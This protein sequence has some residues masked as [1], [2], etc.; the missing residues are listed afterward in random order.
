MNA[1]FAQTARADL[2]ALDLPSEG[3]EWNLSLGSEYPGASGNLDLQEEDSGMSLLLSGDFTQGGAYVAAELEL[4]DLAEESLLFLKLQYRSERAAAMALRLIDETGQVFQTSLSL[5]ADSGLHEL[6]FSAASESWDEY[7]GGAGDGIWRGGIAYLSLILPHH[8][9]PDKTPEI[10]FT[11]IRLSATEGTGADTSVVASYSFDD[12]E[13]VVDWQLSFATLASNAEG[14]GV[15]RLQRS[16]LTDQPVAKSPA[17]AIEGNRLQVTASGSTSLGSPDNS[18]RLVGE[19]IFLNEGQGEIQKR[20]AF[21]QSGESGVGQLSALLSV[22]QDAAYA[23]FQARIEK[24]SGY[25]DIEQVLI[26]QIHEDDSNTYRVEAWSERL[27]NLF[28]PEEELAFQVQASSGDADFDDQTYLLCTVETYWGGRIGPL[29]KPTLSREERVLSGELGLASLPLE[30]GRFYSLRVSLVKAG[31]LLA[32]ELYGFSIL[33]E[34]P[35][36][37]HPHEAVPFTARNWDARLEE[38]IRLASRMG[39]RVV[40]LWGGWNKE[41]PYEPWLSQVELARELDL[42]WIMGTPAMELERG[43]WEWNRENLREGM[44]AFL[45]TFGEQGVFAISTGNEPHGSEEQIPLFVEGYRGIYEGAKSFD[46]NLEVIATSVGPEEAYWENGFGEWSDSYDMHVYQGYRDV[47]DSY[48]QHLDLAGRYGVEMPIRS[49]E[50]GLNSQGMP[51]HV[52]AAEVWKSLG[53][54]FAEGGQS[55]AWFG[56]L[57]PDSDATEQESSGLSHCLFASHYNRYHA[58][59]DAVAYYHFVNG[60]AGKL[61]Q[62]RFDDEETGVHLIQFLDDAGKSM[63]VAWGEFGNSSVFLPSNEGMALTLLQVDGEK[64]TIEVGSAGLGLR[65]QESPILIF[66]DQPLEMQNLVGKARIQLDELPESASRG[67]TF[68]CFLTTVSEVVSS[69]ELEFGGST[70]TLR[71]EGG[72]WPDELE[73]QVPAE[74][75]ASTLWLKVKGMSSTGETVSVDRIQ[76]VVADSAQGAALFRPGDPSSLKFQ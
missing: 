53:T 26:E 51:R 15:L 68:S 50:I 2:D 14:S 65:L 71:A 58:K 62:D 20:L 22:P 70:Q 72:I 75:T 28:Y 42:K 30:T 7:W 56:F 44:I 49:T 13:S 25:V 46:P 32:S 12:E 34:A 6:S 67:A 59:V 24:A 10:R 69:I 23:Q 8:A 57:Y 35:A 60:M 40:N 5:E 74:E 54:F 43:D 41:A 55:A 37:S 73:L 11:Q 17:F 63:I 16:A 33:R 61:Y 27:A 36:N 31:E 9:W 47:Q 3:Q 21:E 38:Y 18:Y 4:S 29:F 66:C 1:V 19:I 48:R 76:I 45:Q 64:Q 39:I 52:V